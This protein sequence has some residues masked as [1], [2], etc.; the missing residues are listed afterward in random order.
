MYYNIK[1]LNIYY[2]IYF[3]MSTKLGVSYSEIRDKLRTCDL[4]LFKGGDVVSNT[5]SK[6]EK[7]ENGCGDFTHTGM[8]IRAESFYY[9]NNKPSWLQ[10]GK[11]YILESTISGYKYISDGIP[12]LCFYIK[13]YKTFIRW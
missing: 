6:V 11:I 1:I 10:E 12:N 9:P 2:N 4:L 5:I 13:L 8:C 7:Y 3:D